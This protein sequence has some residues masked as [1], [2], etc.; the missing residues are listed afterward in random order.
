MGTATTTS[1]LSQLMKVYYDKALL[2]YAK[3]S[4]VIDDLADKSKDIPQKEGKTVNFTRWIP[5]DIVTAE[6]PEGENP[7]YVE[8]KAFEFEKTVAKYTNS[9]R[10]T[11]M[12]ELTAYSDVTDG[13][14]MVAGENMGRSINRLYRQAMATGF[15]PMRVDND[16]TYA[17]TGTVGNTNT[18]TSCYSNLTSDNDVYNDGVIIFTSGRN[19]GSAHL[20]TDYAKTNGVVTFTPALKDAPVAGDTFRIVATT[21]LASTD[22]IT[23][24]AVNRAVSLLKYFNAPK[25]D[26]KHYIGLLDPFVQYDFMNDSNWVNAQ[27][28][29]SPENIKNGEVGKWGGVRWYE[30]TEPYMELITDG[31]AHESPQDRGFGVYNAAGTIRHT[32]IFG[33]HAIAGTRLDGVK[34]KLIIKVSGPQD[35]SNA[36]NAFSLVSWRAIF[37]ATVLNGTFGVN[38]LSTATTVA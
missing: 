26:G 37:V 17:Q 33:A 29:A 6:T 1:T 14:V 5:I 28:Y 13:A 19:K 18:T 16:T 15:Y 4:M 3:P 23:T 32:P 25:Y 34:D 12:L 36:T 31:S 10:L 38:L 7:D 35:T 24:S 2:H 11:D 30:D 22:V 9:I 21:G 20:V 8:L 27:H